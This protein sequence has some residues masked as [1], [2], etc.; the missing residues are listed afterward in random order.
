MLYP[1]Y[2][3]IEQFKLT[4]FSE[5]HFTDCCQELYVSQQVKFSPHVLFFCYSDIS[6]LYPEDYHWFDYYEIQVCPW[7]SIYGFSVVNNKGKIQREIKNKEINGWLSTL[8]PHSFNFPYFLVSEGNIVI[9]LKGKPLSER[10]S[11][12][13]KWK[14]RVKENL[15]T[16][17]AKNISFPV[18]KPVTIYLDVFSTKYTKSLVSDH[19]HLPDT[20]RFIHPITD[21]LEG[22][23]IKN[24]RQ[25]NNVRARIWDVTNA[26]D[27]LE[28]RSEPMG[29]YSLNNISIGCLYPLSMLEKNYYVIRVAY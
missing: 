14:K 8:K 21:M 10:A 29:L 5:I 18:T 6:Y 24:D 17:I 1:G 7:D 12:I 25:V 2:K 3:I 4:P 13:N 28:V 20:D 27:K 22:V 19:Q 23:V 26:F 15:I 16:K 11:G 9:I